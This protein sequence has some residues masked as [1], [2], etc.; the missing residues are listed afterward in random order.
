[1]DE[2][3]IITCG[4]FY[5]FHDRQTEIV[6]GYEMYNSLFRLETSI[7]E[8]EINVVVQSVTYIKRNNMRF[9]SR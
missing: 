9:V 3:Q 8:K 1:M 7:V 5:I 6:L 2:I 4:A